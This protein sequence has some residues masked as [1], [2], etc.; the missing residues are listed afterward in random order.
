M[1]SLTSFEVT[2]RPLMWSRKGSYRNF[3]LNSRS[4]MPRFFAA[5]S[6]H[7]RN[8]LP[9]EPST[10]TQKSLAGIMCIVLRTVHVLTRPPL[11][12][13]SAMR[14]E[15]WNPLTLAQNDEKLSR[16]SW[17]LMPQLASATLT[18]DLGPLALC[19]RYCEASSLLL[20]A[21]VLD[22]GSP[23]LLHRVGICSS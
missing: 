21:F 6:N 5:L 23:S 4:G 14:S 2:A 17:E 19:E 9:G 10:C 18:T 22:S 13:S 8:L 1:N 12:L 11:G 15:S 3:I 7:G 20:R 16:K